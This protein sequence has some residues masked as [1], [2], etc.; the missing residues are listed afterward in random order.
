MITRTAIEH[1]KP[2]IWTG[3]HLLS[4]VMTDTDVI[5]MLFENGGLLVGGAGKGWQGGGHGQDS[6]ENNNEFHFENVD[7]RALEPFERTSKIRLWFSAGWDRLFIVLQP[8]QVRI[9]ME[10]RMAN[11]AK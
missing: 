6:S 5:I 8:V 1:S 9:S 2:G 4:I 10:N 11:I 7:W 3:S